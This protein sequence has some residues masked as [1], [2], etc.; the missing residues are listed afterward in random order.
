M[1][2]VERAKEGRGSKNWNTM[3]ETRWGKKNPLRTLVRVIL[4]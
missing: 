4:P 1:E 2:E 3:G